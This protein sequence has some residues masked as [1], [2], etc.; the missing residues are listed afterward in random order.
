MRVG[1][2]LI[3]FQNIFRSFRPIIKTTFAHKSKF[4]FENFSISLRPT[5]YPIGEVHHTGCPI[6]E[7]H[8]HR[9]PARQVER[10]ELWLVGRGPIGEV[11]GR[12]AVVVHLASVQEGEHAAGA[13]RCQAVPC[14]GTKSLFES[15][16]LQVEYQ[17]LYY[18]LKKI[19]AV[20]CQAVPC[21]GTKSLLK[22]SIYTLN[23]NFYAM[24]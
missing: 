13:V 18:V 12:H 4:K 5:G 21:R 19:Y 20:R 9:L 7:V 6:R 24:C 3:F 8:T 17:F 10:V 2:I 16:N 1:K 23:I 11:G 22:L 15:I 14:R